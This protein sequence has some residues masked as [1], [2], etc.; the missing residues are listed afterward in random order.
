[1]WW[2]QRNRTVNSQIFLSGKSFC[3]FNLRG[4]ETFYVLLQNFCRSF[5]FSVRLN[6]VET[7]P[8]LIILGICKVV[9]PIIEMIGQQQ[10]G[11][12]LTW[13]GFTIDG[14]M[15]SVGLQIGGDGGWDKN[16]KCTDYG[17]HL[18]CQTSLTDSFLNTTLPVFNYCCENMTNSK[19]SS[20]IPHISNKQVLRIYI[21]SQNP[22]TI[23]SV[24]FI[25]VM[26]I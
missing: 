10:L 25:F 19:Y 15:I 21:L 4:R 23:S 8:L 11:V 2:I 13:L 22:V 3:N 9:C 12:L 18:T 14:I 7:L 20:N 1:M 6:G 26:Y 5:H 16:N 17:A 24:S